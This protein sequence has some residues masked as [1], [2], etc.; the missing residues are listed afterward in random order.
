MQDIVSKVHAHMPLSS[1][2]EISG[3]DFAEEAESRNIFQS[4]CFAEFR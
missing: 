1:S 2:A 4:L 3:D